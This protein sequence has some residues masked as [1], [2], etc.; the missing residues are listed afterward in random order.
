MLSGADPPPPQ[1][2]EKIDYNRA[3]FGAEGAE[4]FEH[5]IQSFLTPQNGIFWAKKGKNWP[6]FENL[7]IVENFRKVLALMK[8]HWP[9]KW[10]KNAI[11]MNISGVDETPQKAS[12]STTTVKDVP[13]GFSTIFTPNKIFLWEVLLMYRNGAIPNLYSIGTLRRSILDVPT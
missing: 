7:S 12:P 8:T 6:F 5:K 13:N 9:K 2:G 1:I 10:P 4:I 3:I 11:K